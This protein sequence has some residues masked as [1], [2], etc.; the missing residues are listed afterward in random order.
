MADLLTDIRAVAWS[1]GLRRDSPWHKT[2]ASPGQEKEQIEPTTAS[3]GHR[4]SAFIQ[5]CLLRCVVLCAETELLSIS[6]NYYT[7]SL[8]DPDSR[9]TLEQ[10]E[11]KVSRALVVAACVYCLISII[12]TVTTLA[13]MVWFF[14]RTR[15]APPTWMFPPLFGAKISW[16]LASKSTSLPRAA[17]VEH[18]RLTNQTNL[19]AFWSQT[20]HDAF[21]FS[22]TSLTRRVRFGANPP[23]L[24]VKFTQG[25]LAF[26]L[27]GLFHAAASYAVDKDFGSAFTSFVVFAIQPAA[28]LFQLLVR[29]AL[30]AF[31]FPRKM[32]D[33]V[34]AVLG[35][36][37]LVLT[38]NVLADT[39][40]FGCVLQALSRTPS[41]VVSLGH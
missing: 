9:S 31:K 32:S 13:Q 25:L 7:H 28:I 17:L 37:W 29:R 3:G 35:F 19:A 8:H 33:I 2:R 41:M 1:Y 18:D 26:A 21:H 34:A 39:S 14:A 4:P 27:S 5:G 36:G 16:D 12:H 22:L 24:I 15:Q 38:A 20:W 40:A 30:K 6:A 10:L 23:K 11:A